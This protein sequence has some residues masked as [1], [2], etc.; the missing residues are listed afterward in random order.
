VHVVVND[1]AVKEPLPQTDF[2]FFL[3]VF[4]IVFFVTEGMS[5]G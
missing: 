3:V 2:A 5:P 1:P 4:L